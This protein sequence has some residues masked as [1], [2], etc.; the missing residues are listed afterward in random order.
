M[1]KLN[2]LLLS[3]TDRYGAHEAIYR[4]GK[5]LSKEHNILFL[6]KNKTKTDKWIIE[7]PKT[8]KTFTQKVITLLKKKTNH[9]NKEFFKNNKYVFLEGEDERE[10]YV[11]GNEIINTLGNFIPKII[12]AGIT[13]MFLNTKV[14]LYLHEKTGAAIYQQMVDVFPLT[15]RCHLMWNCNQYKTLCEN[16]PA[17][18]NN[19]ERKMIKNNHL[20]RIDSIKRGSFRLLTVKGWAVDKANN[21]MSYKDRAIALNYNLV[22]TDLFT[23]E[24]R[25]VAKKITGFNDNEF[26]I[27]AGAYN[28]NASHKGAKEFAMSLPILWSLL[29]NQQ[30]KRVTV[31][32]VGHNIDDSLYRNN[33]FNIKKID[34]INDYRY[35]SLI[36]QA[37]DIVVIPS[38][39]DAGPMMTSE[40]LACGT[41]VVGFM[42]GSLFDDGLIQNG[43]QGYRVEI[44][45]VN[46]L[47]NAM[48]KI[49]LLE[50]NSYNT[51]R[52]EARKTALKNVSEEAYLKLFNEKV[53]RQFQ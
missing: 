48:M 1:D 6:V 18:R 20:I 27:F 44:G 40:A 3:T 19:K 25:D 46:E 17:A 39:E 49:I 16:C 15:A 5:V 41:P 28:A 36:Y 11:S 4:M 10:D 52:K 9:K 23:D 38:I 47:A 21:S 53:C 8:K 51:M 7:Q 2:I 35:L 24:H 13:N 42:T 12:I 37:S 26:V 33:R 43:V 34:F 30:R 14:L 31:I 22:D 50:K 32:I 29:D 45:N